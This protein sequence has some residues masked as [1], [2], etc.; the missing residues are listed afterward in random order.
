MAKHQDQPD[1]ELSATR[2][3]EPTEDTEEK[4][5]G[6]S[7]VRFDSNVPRHSRHLSK[8]DFARLGVEHGA[9][10]VEAGEVVEVTPEA[11]EALVK[12]GE[13]KEVDSAEDAKP[14]PT[15]A[16]NIQDTV[17]PNAAGTGGG[18]QVGTQTRDG[19]GARSAQRS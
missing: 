4:S 12:L 9:I 2:P 17:P 1:E 6:G 10:K 16:G 15:L 13:F 11:A 5:A 19:A 14:T 8:A 3:A 18:S 7:F